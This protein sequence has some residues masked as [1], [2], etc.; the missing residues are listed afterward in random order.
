M[1]TVWLVNGR[2][3]ALDPSDRGI[4][5]GDGL[6][7]T[8]A[9][10]GG[11]VRRLAAHL[12]RLADGCRR[13]GFDAPDDETLRNEIAAHV[14]AAGRAVVKLIVT[15]GPGARGYL[16]P[17]VARPTRILAISSW[18]GHPPHHY[19][20]GMTLRTCALR[21]GQNPAL[22][23][24][25]HLNRLE[26]VL[27]SAETRAAGADEGLLLDSEGRVVCATG[28]NVF[29]V[30]GATLVTPAVTRCGV[31]GV[32]RR[33][34]LEAASALGLAAAVRDVAPAE[35]RGATEIFLSNAVAGIRP[36][37]ALDDLR[38]AAGPL[39]RRLTAHLS[40]ADGAA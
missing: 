22:A 11:R 21:L 7:E 29:A 12:E 31:A 36:V 34:V 25:K 6:F 28:N 24:I 10:D 18:P 26:H 3:E 13:L 30:L 1:D 2:R 35:L 8:M 20:A 5:Y 15:R 33:A 39:T 4:A 17:A 40:A 19:T 38:L 9:A 14:P 23:G 32:M 37:A 16:P 27:A